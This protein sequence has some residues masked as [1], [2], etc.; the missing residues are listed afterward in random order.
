M[1]SGNVGVGQVRPQRRPCYLERRQTGR[2]H[3]PPDRQPG[4]DH[5]EVV[6]VPLAADHGDAERDGFVV[7]HFQSQC[8]IFSQDRLTQ[9]ARERRIGV[10]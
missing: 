6:G 3:D 2:A 1:R 8:T 9:P 5:L 7:D 4:P 10:G